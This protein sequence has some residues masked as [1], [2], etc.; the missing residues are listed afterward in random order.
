MHAPREGF[1]VC[2]HGAAWHGTPITVLQNR[3]LLK[4]IEIAT[5]GG[6]ADLEHLAKFGHG[7]PLAI[8]DQL[9]NVLATLLTQHE[10]YPL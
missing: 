3:I 9:P 1:R 8:C 5:D 7:G 4:L 2:L 10:T 6:S